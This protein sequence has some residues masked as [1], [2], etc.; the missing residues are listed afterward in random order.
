VT[1]SSSS[2]STMSATYS[3]TYSVCIP[4]IFT[5]VPN[6]KIVGTFEK[7]NLGKVDK[8]DII[9]KTGRDGSSYKMAFVHFSEWNIYNSAAITF[10][11]QV[12]NPN[13]E[14][15]LVYDDPWYWI[16]LPNHSY[17]MYK[18]NNNNNKLPVSTES[19]LPT[20]INNNHD[21]W[22]DQ[23]SSANNWIN[24]RIA[25]LEEELTYIYEELYKREFIPVKYRNVCE[26]NTDIETGNTD[27][28]VYG[29]VSP[30]TIDELDCG[31]TN[32]AGSHDYLNETYDNDTFET[33]DD[34]A[35]N[36]ALHCAPST[37]KLYSYNEQD[38]LDYYVNNINVNDN[39]L[40]NNNDYCGL[41]GDKIAITI[42]NDIN[43]IHSKRW[44]TMNC[45]GNN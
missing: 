43:D 26:W 13:K 20:H 37:T 19:S 8:L 27:E 25:H 6:K 39:Y 1:Q 2:I 44:M 42:N 45:C 40:Q 31:N 10:R 41:R 29:N 32:T 36:D 14:A 24:D 9:W 38:E 17:D 18:Q 21:V 22:Q 5:N 28:P 16:V 3:A 35:K 23:L 34:D 12:E 15:R 33:Y 4:R 30:M 7:L 11:E